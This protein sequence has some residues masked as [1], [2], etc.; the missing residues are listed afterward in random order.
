MSTEPVAA[1]H[2]LAALLAKRGV[3]R[4]GIID[5]AYDTIDHVVVQ[6]EEAEDL[7]A[8][9]EHQDEAREEL[10]RIGG[11]TAEP[12]LI[13]G[14]LVAAFLS[15]REEYPA[16]GGLWDT[17][18]LGVRLYERTKLLDRFTAHLEQDLALDVRKLGRQAQLSDP[19]IKLY[20]LDWYLGEDRD[21]DPVQA[22]VEKAM[23]IYALCPENEQKPLI[24]LMSSR[25]GVVDEA[26][27]FRKRSGLLGGMFYTL[28]KQELADPV[29]LE[30]HL[31]MY[32][33]SLPA[34]HQVQRFVEA[35]REKVVTVGHQFA[36][37]INELTLSD[38]AF[39]QRLSLQEDGHP[40]GDYILWLFGA[41]FGHLL[42]GRALRDERADLD[43]MRFEQALPSHDVPSVRLAQV[44]Q[45]ALFDM[46][47]GPLSQHPRGRSTATH[48]P[49]TEPWLNLGDLFLCEGDV[50]SAPGAVKGVEDPVPSDPVATTVLANAAPGETSPSETPP[51]LF[52]V[53]NNQC[54]L[55]FTPDDDRA[56]EPDR[57]ILLL[58]GTLQ[59]LGDSLKSARALRTE[60]FTRGG[61][62]FRIIWDT[63]KVRS[64]PY[65]AFMR[66]IDEQRLHLRAR[67]R[68]P[69]ALEVQRA[70]A[71]D[72]TRIGMPVPPP[73]YQPLTVELLEPQGG[74]LVRVDGGQ[75]RRAFVVLT[76][77]GSQCVLT[78]PLI[79]AVRKALE[80]QRQVMQLENEQRDPATKEYARA[81]QKVNKLSVLVSSPDTWL[82]LLG[83]LEIPS[84]GKPRGVPDID[85]ALKLSRGKAAGD[86]SNQNDPL[87][88]IN[89]IDL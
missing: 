5:D 8:S 3:G 36:D 59:P 44:Y 10:E 55:S 18:M 11:D 7:W 80:A 39:I 62:S 51:D 21:A 22:A 58:P 45:C 72:L 38:Y 86:A 15:R 9:I 82:T 13:T 79:T 83:E 16:L 49:V 2:P 70:F 61:D 77:K 69:F 1:Q 28:P 20:F 26:E 52:M 50:I 30:I 78:L 47:V 19:T 24:V 73:I 14:K 88:F 12:G 37:D 85:W 66:W 33:R 56:I 6:P 46:D 35:I 71:A 42:F 63:K 17:S 40:L 54:D 23:Q 74:S 27:D 31:H 43:S 81:A 60:L 67:L 34:G 4:V 57:A 48:E 32:A 29:T 65:A 87:I 76:R 68:L 41:Y 25:P 89:L 75:Q 53:I 64:V 84:P